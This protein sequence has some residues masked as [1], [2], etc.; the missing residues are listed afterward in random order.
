VRRPNRTRLLELPVPLRLDWKLRFP[1]MQ[2][3]G[4]FGDCQAYTKTTGGSLAGHVNMIKRPENMRQIRLRKPRP[5]IPYSHRVRGSG[6]PELREVFSLTSIV[7]FSPGRLCDWE[8]LSRVGNSRSYG[9]QKNRFDLNLILVP[10]LPPLGMSFLLAFLETGTG[11]GPNLRI[12]V[13]R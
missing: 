8:K 4:T 5:T 2:V 7:M 9:V 3:H 1:R 6:V 10:A 13:E 11:T 12:K